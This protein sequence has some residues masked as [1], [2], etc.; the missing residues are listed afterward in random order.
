MTSQS[1]KNSWTQ[2]LEQAVFALLRKTNEELTEAN[3]ALTESNQELTEEVSKL[4]SQVSKLRKMLFGRKSEKLPPIQSEVRR[5]VDAE[6]L[7]G[8]EDDGDSA[9]EQTPLTEEEAKKQRRKR[10]RAKS[11][12]QRKKNRKLRKNLP[13]IR[14]QVSIKAEDLPEGYTLDDFREVGQRGHR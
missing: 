11:E 5:V 10:G 3:K 14:E 2:L 12:P 9:A 1:S 13:V 4:T 8:E 6:E 7:F